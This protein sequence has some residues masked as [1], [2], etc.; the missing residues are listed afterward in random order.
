[1][2]DPPRRGRARRP[3]VSGST[4]APSP[5]D[6]LE[7]RTLA[8]RAPGGDEAILVVEDQDQVRDVVRSI[9]ERLG[10]RVATARNADE[11]LGLV[12]DGIPL[13]LLIADV[14]LPAMNG[15]ALAERIVERRPHVRVLVM[16]GFT[17]ES[18]LPQGE[19]GGRPCGFLLKPVTLPGLA[20]AVRDALDSG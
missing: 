15:V 17:S 10:Y 7:S 9:L 3:W 2:S 12:R 20:R 6:D 16:S 8:P 19:I 1:M 11:A 5:L 18:A 13:D 14:V 4:P